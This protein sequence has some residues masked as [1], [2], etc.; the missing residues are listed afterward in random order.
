[1]AQIL[2]KTLYKISKGTV[3]SYCLVILVTLVLLWVAQ[4]KGDKEQKK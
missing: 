1:M 2:C 3:K 4:A